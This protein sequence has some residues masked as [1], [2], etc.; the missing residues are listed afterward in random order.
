MA[1]PQHKLSLNEYLAWENEQPDKN[2]FYRGE[3]FAMVGA[4][5]AHGRV[6]LNLGHAL[7]SRLA[8]SPGQ[9]FAEGMK[10]QVADDAVFYP[11]LMVTCDKAD[12]ATEMIFRAPKVIVEVLSPSTQ[13]YDR[14]LKFAAY[15]RLPSL[16]EF[17][18]IDPDL[19][20]IEGYRRTAQDQWLYVDMSEGPALEVP[21][22]GCSIP[23]AEV[24]DGLD[25]PPA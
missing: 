12:L 4:R 1:V 2:E 7:M 16:Q 8:G 18:L 22:L 5:R 15:R 24:F 23:L 25:P 11:D 6:V 20:R 13:S 9:V 21:S 17:I 19:R 10:L 3:V 14:G